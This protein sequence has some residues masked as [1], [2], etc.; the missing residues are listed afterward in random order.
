[1]NGRYEWSFT[2]QAVLA[3]TTMKMII[4]SYTTNTNSTTTINS[5]TIQKAQRR[6]RFQIETDLNLT[7]KISLL[8][9]PFGSGLSPTCRIPHLLV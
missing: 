6:N 2:L 9:V 1:M 5:I 3:I 8:V 4:I 7:S